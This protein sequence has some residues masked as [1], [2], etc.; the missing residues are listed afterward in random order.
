MELDSVLVRLCIES[1]CSSRDSVERWRMQRRT[2]QRLPP[3]LA[4]ALL[5]RL[6]QRRLLSPSLLEAFK[7]CV[8]EVDLRGET[9][10]DAEWMAYLGGFRYLHYL[11]VADCHR[12]TSSALWPIAG[13][14]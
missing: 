2:L 6:L 8:D 11:N 13:L 1:A 7:Y 9:S 3:Q 4:S 12:V 14:L 10:V 5:R